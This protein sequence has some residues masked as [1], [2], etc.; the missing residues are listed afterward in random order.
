MILLLL[1]QNKAALFK[2]GGIMK[3]LNIK[4]WLWLIWGLALSFS[5][6]VYAYT[7][8]IDAQQLRQDYP[9]TYLVSKHDTLWDVVGVFL[10]SPWQQSSMWGE[11]IKVY[12][13]D[14]VSVIREG[15][16]SFLQIKHNRVV[17]LSPQIRTP[18][19]QPPPIEPIPLSSIRQFLNK[20]QVVTDEIL[21][22]APY[23]VHEADGRLIMTEGNEIYVRDLEHAREGEYYAIFRLGRNYGTDEGDSNVYEAIYLGQAKII[24]SGTPTTAHITQAEREI[25]PGDLLLEIEEVRFSQDLIPKTPDMVDDSKI[26]A[27]VDGVSQIGQYQIVVIDKGRRDAVEPGHIF[28]VFSAGRIVKDKVRP[29]RD[30]VTLPQ[31]QAGTLLV[32]KVFDT[33]SYALVMSA[34]RAIYVNDQLG[35][36]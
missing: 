12:P 27:V 14:E 21:E 8:P 23:I 9:H 26:I 10:T 24:A 17:K 18:R 11:E 36:P 7:V 20:P 2:S 13:G 25:R 29:D 33:V 35:L 31:R 4:S 28:A 3:S 16:R 32:F 19:D 5:M 34:T 30:D 6:P 1:C 22:N 15:G